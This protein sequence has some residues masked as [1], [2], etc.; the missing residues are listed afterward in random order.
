M[1]IKM[2][3]KMWRWGAG[4]KP[5]GNWAVVS[6]IADCSACLSRDI[7]L[8]LALVPLKLAHILDCPYSF[9]HPSLCYFTCL[10][11]A[12]TFLGSEVGALLCWMCWALLVAGGDCAV[13][14][15]SLFPWPAG[16]C[17][18]PPWL[19]GDCALHGGFALG[20]GK[21]TL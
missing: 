12:V 1:M 6:F 9:S 11:P 19:H 13:G 17:H 20:A 5:V 4:G 18:P 16:A 8:P 10:L 3:I 14:I 7:W 15:W 21:Y 2:V